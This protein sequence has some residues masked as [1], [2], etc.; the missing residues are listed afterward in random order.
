[1]DIKDPWNYLKNINYIGKSIVDV[2]THTKKNYN[3]F[4]VFLD[5]LIKNNV[6]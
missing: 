5:L 2:F 1:M 6:S 4:V 3:N